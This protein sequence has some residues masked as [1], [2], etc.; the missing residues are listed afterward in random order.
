MQELKAALKAALKQAGISAADG[1][2]WK[3]GP[4][5]KEKGVFVSLRQITGAQ[6]AFQQYLG[7][8]IDGN[9]VYGAELT[10]TFA[11]VLLTPK[12]LGAPE[13]E[14]F[15][16]EIM[17][18]VLLAVG[19]LGVQEILCA[20]AQ[21]DSLRDCFRQEITV[22]SRIMAYGTET[23]SGVALSDFRVKALML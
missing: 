1:R 18:A 13:A 10:V 15:G 11:L 12:E 8:D 4:L 2:A 23:D 6:G 3:M 20:E 9:E 14:A 21:Y 22:Q 17:N 16:E 5:Q 7:Q 19:Q